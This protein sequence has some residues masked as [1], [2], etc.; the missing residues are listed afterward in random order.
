[1]ELAAKMRRRRKK[2]GFLFLR[3]LRFLAAKMVGLVRFELTTSCTPC[4]RATRLRYSPNKMKGHKD[5]RIPARQEL[6]PPVARGRAKR[7][8]APFDRDKNLRTN[9]SPKRPASGKFHA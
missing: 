9:G 8:H 1:M 3:L 6:F 2:S 7:V 5:P 4:K